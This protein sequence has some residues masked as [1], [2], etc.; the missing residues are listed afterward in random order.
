MPNPKLLEVDNLSV[1]RNRSQILAG[2]SL[3]CGEQEILSVLGRSGCG[4]TTLLKAVAGLVR[5]QGEVRIERELLTGPTRKVGLVFQQYCVFPWMT[6]EENIRFG[7]RCG[8]NGDSRS[9]EDEVAELLSATSLA[10][11]RA[12]YPAQISGGMQQRVAIARTLAADPKV[13]LLDEPF[14]ALDAHTRIRMQ[15]LVRGM[16]S[17]MHQAVVLVTHDIREAVLLSDRILV[18]GGKPATIRSEW[19]VTN[20]RSAKNPYDLPPEQQQLASDIL[21]I[22]GAEE[23]TPGRIVRNY[24]HRLTA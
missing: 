11:D 9:I 8:L 4:K 7:A 10:T 23:E 1:F 22:L 18:L 5:A 14:G 13:L 16:F 20:P 17:K 12:K 15:E 6:V 3:S 21:A 24:E 19:A 2:I